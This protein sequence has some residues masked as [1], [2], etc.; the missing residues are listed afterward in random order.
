MKI[1]ELWGNYK[2]VFGVHIS[3]SYLQHSHQNQPKIS[4]KQEAKRALKTARPTGETEPHLSHQLGSLTQLL[5]PTAGTVPRFH[6]DQRSDCNGENGAYSTD[7]RQH[8]RDILGKYDAWW[9]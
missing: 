2:L 4:P 1:Q 9:G 8:C 5:S 6:V 3:T 7:T